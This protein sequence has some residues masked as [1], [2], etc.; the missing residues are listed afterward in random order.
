MAV[1][2]AEKERFMQLQDKLRHSWQDRDILDED[3]TDILVIPS[4]SIDQR[5][6]KKVAG[7]LHYEERQLF[8]L[9]RLRNPHT[10]LIYVTAHPLSPIIVDYYLQLLPGI[11]FSHARERLL[12]LNTYDCSL[13]PLTQKILERPRLVTKIKNSLRPNKSYMVCFNSTPLEEELSIKLDIPL[14]AASPELS[15]WGSKSG[16]REIFAKC[17]LQHPDGSKLVFTMDEL[18]KETAQLLI[19]KP[20]INKVV[21]KLNEGFS[22]EGN[23]V[24]DISNIKSLFSEDLSL[25]KAQHLIAQIIHRAKV[26]G[27]GETWQ[28]YCDRISELGVI[29]E[30]FIEGKEKFSPSVQGYISPHG[31]VEILSTHDQI[32]GGEEQQIYLGCSFPAHDNYR[33]ELQKLGLK[34]GKELATKGVMERF[35]VDFLAVKENNQWSL[36]AIEINLRKGGTTH[37]FMTLKFL[38]N[39]TYNYQD[40]LFYSPEE[41]AKYYIASD[42]LQ[43]PNY[44]GLLPNDLMDIVTKHRLHF[45]SSTK[46]GTIFH[47][48]GALSEFGKLGLTSIGNS[49]EEARDIYKNIETVL[50][51]E[52]L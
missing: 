17:Q 25:T 4:F 36:Y 16:S 10:R 14:L 38:T 2:A 23:A 32:L 28:T 49:P 15:Y 37:P 11:P 13:K 48:M 21:I 51:T 18:I 40:G 30:E 44:H 47:L 12:L 34:I 42:N 7:F 39:G 52:T 8:S 26:Q 3:D 5:V 29:V 45:D 27:E 50:D 9:I 1:T 22:G 33:L 35:G 6:G 46:T 19:R 31:K 43:K 20:H 24:L 41:K